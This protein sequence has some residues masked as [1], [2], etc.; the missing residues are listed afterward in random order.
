MKKSPWVHT[1]IAKRLF[2]YSFL[3]LPQ[4]SASKYCR[5]STN[6]YYCLPTFCMLNL[7]CT[8]LDLLH[9]ATVVPLSLTLLWALL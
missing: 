6:H 1:Y 8:V 2:S 9:M 3:N 4:V 7:L 5:K